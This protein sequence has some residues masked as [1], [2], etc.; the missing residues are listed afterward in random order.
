M[1]SPGKLYIDGATITSAGCG[2]D[3]WYNGA[4]VEIKNSSITGEVA[5]IDKNDATLTVGENVTFPGG[6]TVLEGTLNEYLAEG[7]AYWQG[8]DMIVLTE[9]QTEIT[10]GDVTVK[11]AP[12]NE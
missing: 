8:D 4:S 6:L 5:D 10:N 2:V 9:G 11:A 12:T 3:S 1:G 7:Y